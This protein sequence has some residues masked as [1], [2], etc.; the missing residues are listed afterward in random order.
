M[1]SRRGCFRNKLNDPSQQRTK[2]H[3]ARMNMSRTST[4]AGFGRESM[5][6]IGR[7]HNCNARNT[8]SEKTDE[9]HTAMGKRKTRRSQRDG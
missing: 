8:R 3:V 1:Q 4:K 2:P 5:E 9:K 7:M 6:V